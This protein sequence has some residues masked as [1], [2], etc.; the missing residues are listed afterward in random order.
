MQIGEIS[1]VLRLKPETIRYYEKEGIVSPRRKGEGTFREYSIWDF[2]DLLECRRFREMDFSIKDVKRLMKAEKLDVITEMLREKRQELCGRADQMLSLAAEMESLT[3][4]VSNAPLNIGNYWFKTEEEKIGIH[5][6]ERYSKRYA[7]VDVNN[8]NL[9]SW[10]GK[11]P[12]VNAYMHVLVQDIQ[13]HL[14]RNE[15]FLCTSLARFQEMGLP[16][17][18]TFRIP[19]RVYL[20]TILD[21]GGRESL[22]VKMLEPVL[23]HVTRRG[24]G[25]DDYVVGEFL[26]CSY[27]G[28]T[29][30]RYVEVMI[31]VKE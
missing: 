8:Q 28:K 7:D 21:I 29:L 25:I 2:F 22:T 19:G 14:D 3:D 6:T 31:P 13:D 27:E 12:F 4:R 23:E 1:R 10:L 18:E 15:W 16:E 24:I 17:Q 11:S 30:H 5:F 20:H 26:M 9:Q